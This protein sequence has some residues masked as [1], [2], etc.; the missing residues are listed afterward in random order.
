MQREHEGAAGAEK[1][2]VAPEAI[3]WSR[4][5]VEAEEERDDGKRSER[6]V[7]GDESG[8]GA[9]KGLEGA[10]AE[11]CAVGGGDDGLPLIL[12]DN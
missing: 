4:P 5:E 8:D 9:R 1:V 7:A 12:G 2:E 11:D 10:G 3:F 6:G